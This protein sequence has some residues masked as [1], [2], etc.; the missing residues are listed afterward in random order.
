MAWICGKH[1]IVQQFVILVCSY[2]VISVL[3]S[4]TLSILH[5]LQAFCSELFAY[6]ICISLCRPLSL[7]F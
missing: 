6:W 1:S 7:F 4:G 5:Q 3:D 2:R